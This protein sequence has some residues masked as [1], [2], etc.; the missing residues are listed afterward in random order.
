MSST[1]VR[2]QVQVKH[3]L[4]YVMAWRQLTTTER[5]SLPVGHAVLQQ[6]VERLMGDEMVQDHELRVAALR[7]EAWNHRCSS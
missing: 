7:G 4:E 2:N 6:V 3:F 5:Q 1:V